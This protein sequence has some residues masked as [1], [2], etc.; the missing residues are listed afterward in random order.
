MTLT[1]PAWMQPFAE[2]FFDTG[3]NDVE[4]LINDRTMVQINAPLALL[5]HGAYA[6]YR[7]LERLA[8]SGLLKI[9]ETTVIDDAGVARMAHYG[10]PGEQTWDVAIREGWAPEG[11]AFNAH[12]YV[13]RDPSL[14]GVARDRDLKHGRWYYARLV[15]M[16]LGK[17]SLPPP[18]VGTASQLRAV[19]ILK[20]LQA[21][22]TASQ[23]ALLRKQGE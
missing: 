9:P 2:H 5:A 16:A 11:A 6:Q 19:G 18:P 22:L 23:R 17:G 20:R 15:E 14:K 13:T 12:K 8:A 21:M 10:A 4:N 1:I 7:L 3:G